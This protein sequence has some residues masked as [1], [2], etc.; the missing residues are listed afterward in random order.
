MILLSLVATAGLSSRAPELLDRVGKALGWVMEPWQAERIAI[1]E[2]R[3]QALGDLQRLAIYEEAGLRS[4]GEQLMK[5]RNLV[6]VASEAVR[7]VNDSAQPEKIGTDWIA[8]F[9]A[10]C[11]LTSEPEM[12]SLWAKILAGEANTPGSFSKRT[13]NLVA[14]LDK[15]DAENFTKA[16][17]FVVQMKEPILFVRNAYTPFYNQ[18]GV[19]QNMLLRLQDAG[20]LS[21]DGFN[22]FSLHNPGEIVTFS[23]FDKQVK[24]TATTGP[25]SKHFDFSIFMLTT[26]GKELVPIC[27]AVERPDF[28]AYLIEMFN[29]AP[30][31]GWKGEILL[32]SS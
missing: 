30:D 14:E 27:G 17:T 8:N 12:R 1:A 28:I 22:G 25:H 2:A 13:V 29:K 31:L 19:N 23:Y 16:A 15:T 3:G 32:A 6:A 21:S 10:K 26:T 11:Q 4:L 20:L 24:F 5:E 18:A 9:Y 7:L